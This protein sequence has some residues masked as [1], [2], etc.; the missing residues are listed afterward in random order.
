[1]LSILINIYNIDSSVIHYLPKV[2]FWQNYCDHAQYHASSLTQTSDFPV[3]EP[4]W[5]AQEEMALLEAVMDCGFGNWLVHAHTQSLSL[6]SYITNLQ[7][8]GHLQSV[9]C[10]VAALSCT[11][12][13]YQ[14]KHVQIDYKKT[15]TFLFD[16][17]QAG[18]GV[19]DAHQKQGGV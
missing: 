9:T 18:C 2:C 7:T 10:F 17:A 14:Y 6:S 16:S 3:L 19:S 1:M 8:R 12:C 4:S 13:Q 15:I 11:V 5:T